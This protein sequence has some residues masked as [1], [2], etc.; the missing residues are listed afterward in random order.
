MVAYCTPKK[1]GSLVGTM[2]LR[3]SPDNRRMQ[4]KITGIDPSNDQIYTTENE[5]KRQS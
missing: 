1:E 4:G 2:T 3:I 5:W